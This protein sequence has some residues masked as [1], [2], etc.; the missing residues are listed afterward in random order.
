MHTECLEVGSALSHWSRRQPR[1]IA[2]K[3]EMLVAALK[4][5]AERPHSRGLRQVVAK[6]A[7]ELDALAH[8]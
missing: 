6:Q 2:I 3:A 1:L 7:A 8:R 4:L 5:L